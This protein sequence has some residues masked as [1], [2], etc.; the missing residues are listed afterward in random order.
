MAPFYR[1]HGSVHH[2]IGPIHADKND[3]AKFAQIYIYDQSSQIDGRCSLLECLDKNI[4]IKIQ[5][6]LLANNTFLKVFY[7]VGELLCVK[8]SLELSIVIRS[9]IISAKKRY[10]KPNENEVAI[11]LGG[12]AVKILLLNLMLMPFYSY[13]ERAISYIHYFG[14]LYHQYIVD[15]MPKSNPLDSHL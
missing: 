12:L 7:N 2:Y 11:L 10:N 5:N 9:D 13:Q 1:I 14:K 8:P 6:F 3:E 15:H 4:I